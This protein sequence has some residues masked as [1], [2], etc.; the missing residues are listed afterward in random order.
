IAWPLHEPPADCVGELRRGDYS[1][2]ANAHEQVSD[3]GLLPEVPLRAPGVTA[4]LD[5]SCA[6]HA[7]WSRHRNRLAPNL[8]DEARALLGPDDAPGPIERAIGLWIAPDGLPYHIPPVPP[9]YADQP[10]IA[11]R[12]K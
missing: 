11:A 1:E 3:L 8:P 9:A 10:E 5:V 7:A 12:C 6:W 2:I 4:V